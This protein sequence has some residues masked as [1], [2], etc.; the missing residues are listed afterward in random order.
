[1]KT[2]IKFSRIY[3]C[4]LVWAGLSSCQEYLDV[5]PKDRVADATLWTDKGNA[6]LFLNGIYGSIRGPIDFFDHGD[7][8][9]DNTISQYLWADSRGLYVL[10]IETPGTNSRLQ[11]WAQYTNIRKCNVFISKAEASSLDPAWKKLRIAEAKFLRAYFY[12]LLWTTYGGVPLITDVLDRNTQGAEIF[13]AR[14][15]DAATFKFIVDECAAIANDLPLKPG[16][17]RA[18]KGAAL[19]L[20]AW[21]ELFN[22]GPLKNP[23][24]DRARWALAAATN[25]QIMNLKTYSLFP[26]R[27]T[28]L[29]ESNNGNSEV[30]FDKSYLGGTTIGNSRSGLQP[31]GVVGG[32]QNSWSGVNVTQELVDDYA[33]ANGLPI[34]DPASGYN[35]QKPYEN[36][37][38]RFYQ[39]IIYD[40][41]TF[42][43]QEAIYWTGSGSLNE[44]DLNFGGTNRPATVYHPR[45][46]IENQYYINGWNNMSSAN[47]VIFRYAE[48]VLSYAEAQ[49]E[50]VGP[51]ASVYDAINMVRARV[52]LPA[53]KAG[54]TQEQMRVAIQ[55]E[56]RVELCFED[57][58]W[59]DLIRLK[60]AEKLIP[61]TVHTMKIE[62]VNG[63]KKYTVV[64]TGGTNRAF[65]PAKNYLLPIPRTAMD[66]NKK[67]INNPVYGNN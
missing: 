59:P 20:K 1:M 13:R 45:K 26:D 48:V 33:M 31:I 67:L 2:P 38:K 12:S 10:G 21:C 7:N 32:T 51:D 11:Q 57:K 53:M 43:G 17:S 14:D 61:K 60:L 50:A 34:S 65:D 19:T 6:D 24:N 41:S 55:R 40:G 22:A 42:M 39:D 37:E 54:L 62:K 29:F 18:S 25:Q 27:E 64:E 44:L 46:A 4:L 52:G 5:L 66:R 30:I 28:L 36:R 58:R 15:T 47:W 35:P 3:I 23:T 8:Y 9:T 63:V 49:N 56:R 16:K